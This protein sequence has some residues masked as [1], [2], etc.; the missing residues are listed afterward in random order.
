[1]EI[2]A[3][4]RKMI[5]D[6]YNQ[7]LEAMVEFIG[8]LLAEIEEIKRINQKQE[9]RI[10]TIERQI[11]KDSHNSNKPPSSDGLNRNIR[12]NREK[13]DRASG[14]QE[15]H[16]GT[17]LQ[18]VNNPDYRVVHAV[19]KC[20]KCGRSLKKV[21][22]KDH[23]RRQVFDLPTTIRVKVT[24]HRAESK[25]CPDCGNIT[26]ARF[27]ESVAKAA[28]YGKG[29]KAVGVYLMEQH[30]I[31]FER[32]TELMEDLFGCDVTEGSLQNWRQEAYKKLEAAEE[33]VK[34]QLREAPVVN[35]DETGIFCEN[36]LHWLH[37]ASTDKLTN[38]ALHEKRGKAATD[39]IDIIPHV[40]G[41]LIHD[42]WESYLGYENC[43]HGL[44]NSHI[45]RE[46]T[47]VF[48]ENGQKWAQGLIDHLYYIHKKILLTKPK[49]DAFSPQTLRRYEETYDSLVQSGLRLNR[50][51]RGS[52]HQRGRIKQSKARNLLERLRDYRDEIL[53]FMYDF[54]VPF[55]NNLAERDIRMM[56]VKQK[57]SG[58]F[59]SR[60][61]AD[62]FCRIRGYISTVKK[63]SI[64]VFDALVDAFSGHP[65]IPSP[66]HA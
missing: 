45:S 55:T 44:C 46:L 30:L 59:R 19:E 4:T 42:F 6:I 40:K 43:Q 11:N 2:D 28:Q 58:T 50:R 62:Y 60:A 38:Y 22:S 54:Q 21:S 57:I 26:T 33:A 65:F 13:S 51:N 23:E 56:K 52:P 9:E 61:G 14:G 41:R 66:N 35:A 32:T 24:E 47:S 15:G 25:E 36:K 39:E 12:S 1:M 5:V 34:E 18:M 27:P 10:K 17:T 7:G 37:V 49:R 29:V 63:N 8:V 48:E 16:P 53:A 64:N 31:P 20:C 3:R